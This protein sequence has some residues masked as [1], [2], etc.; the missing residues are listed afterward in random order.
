M[1]PGRPRIGAAL[2]RGQ[3]AAHDLEVLGDLVKP[4]GQLLDAPQQHRPLGFD[5]EQFEQVGD[6]GGKAAGRGGP[7]HLADEILG[8]RRAFDNGAVAGGVALAEHRMPVEQ[9]GDAPSPM[10]ADYEGASTLPGFSSA[11]ARCILVAGAL[12]NRTVGDEAHIEVSFL[13]CH[14]AFHRVRILHGGIGS[15]SGLVDISIS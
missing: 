2:W 12:D 10:K 4:L 15:G 11:E 13:A 9:R 14:L 7:L 8:R 6:I 1:L 3:H 5:F